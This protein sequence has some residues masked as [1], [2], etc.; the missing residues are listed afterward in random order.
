MREYQVRIC[1]GL[2]VKFPGPTR[3]LDSCCL[4]HLDYPLEDPK[5]AMDMAGY[6]ANAHVS[7]R[8]PSDEGRLK[9]PPP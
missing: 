8:P 7:S 3:Q 6:E 4:A 5:A 2:G 1:E 9:L